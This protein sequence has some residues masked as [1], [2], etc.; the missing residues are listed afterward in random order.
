[1]GNDDAEYIKNIKEKHKKEGVIKASQTEYHRKSH[2]L[3][4]VNEA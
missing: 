4:K 1:M 3:I 2:T